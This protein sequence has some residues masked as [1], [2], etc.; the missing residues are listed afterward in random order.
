MEA[1]STAS[2]AHICHDRCAGLPWAKMLDEFRN[3]PRISVQG[4]ECPLAGTRSAKCDELQA[5]TEHLLIRR[6]K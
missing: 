2:V 4:M 5:A 6:Q 3:E 1:T